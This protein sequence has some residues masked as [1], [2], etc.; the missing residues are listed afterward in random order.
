[1]REYF[2][3]TQQQVLFTPAKDIVLCAGRGWGKGPIH[4]AINLRN[5]QRMP[6]SITGFV[7]ANCKRAL[8]NT[9][10]SMLIHWQR[11]GFKRDVHWTIG[12]KPPKSWG[13]GEPIFQPDNW[14]NV[15]SFYN[16]SI[17]YIISQ[18]RSGTSNSFSLDYLDIDEAKYIDFEQLKDETLPAN[19]GNKQY[20]GHHYFHHGMLIT[21]DMPVIK[22]GSWFLD[23][24][25][26][27]DPELIEVIQATVHEIWRTKKRIRDLQAKSEPVPLYLKDYL[28]T[29]NRDVCRMGSVAVLYREF[30]TIENMQLLGEAFINQMKR[31][32]PPLTFQTAILCR[33]IGISRDGFYSSMTEGHKYNAT[34]FS[35]LD[36][37]EYQFDKI[38]E[39]SCLMDAD[40]DRDKPICIAFDFNANINWLVAGQP[41]RNRLK[42]IKSFWVKYERKLEALVDDFCKYYRHQRNKLVNFYYDSTALGS[43]YAVNDEDFHYVIEHC[44]I[45]R[46]WEV[47]SVYIG[48]PMKH[49]EKW[50]LLNRMFA[51]KARL[52]PFFNVQNNEDLLISVQTAGVY[53]GGKDKRGEKLAETEEDQLQARRFKLRFGN[54]QMKLVRGFNVRNLLEHGHQFREVEELGK[55]RSRPIA[56][57]FRGKFDGRGR[58]AKSGCP[59][60]EVGQLF[61]LQGAILQIPHDRVK[62]GHGV[63]HRGAGGEH[64]APASGDLV[65]IAA[66]AEHIAG[67]LG[68]AGG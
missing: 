65:Q 44:F 31:D 51:G 56:C 41:D 67:L 19:R 16:G 63:A 46:G 36:S 21:S 68:F 38:K 9:I 26:K 2:H 52:V 58:L 34:D 18:D 39:P 32:L 33:R 47:N 11:W 5:M 22:K 59:A 1:M 53:N 57:T 4:A 54:R 50:L 37:L 49:I 23:Y 66:L 13:W 17:G 27:C 20:F 45:D 35:Y 64:H 55:S 15:I 14:E 28:R 6:G 48:P 61:L 30:S 3:D 29:L 10:P 42:V 7:A 40:L 8:T 25:K 43:N 62:L 24:E 12:K 60:V